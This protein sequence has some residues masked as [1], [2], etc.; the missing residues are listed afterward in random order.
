MKKQQCVCKLGR[1]PD[2]RSSFKK[3]R[4]I[5]RR[6][7]LRQACYDVVVAGGGPSGMGAALAAARQ[8]AR[9]LLVE[10]NGFSGGNAT[11]GYVLKFHGFVSKRRNYVVRGIPL[12]LVRKMKMARGACA[13][14]D[15]ADGFVFDPEC[16][17]RTADDLLAAAGVE[18]LFHSFAADVIRRKHD[19]EGV[20]IENKSGPL[21]VRGKVFIDA[22]GTGDVAIRAGAEYQ[23]GR[24]GDQAMQ[25]MSLGFRLG[26]VAS[27]DIKEIRPLMRQGVAAG[28]IPFIGGP[29]IDFTGASPR[30]GEV[31]VNAVRMWGD[32]SDV[33]DLT[34]AEIEGRK[35]VEKITAF[36]KKKA[37]PFSKCFLVDSAPVISFREANHILGDYIL[38][39]EDVLAGRKFEDGIAA[40][41]WGVDIHSPTPGV[42][43]N[44]TGLDDYYLIPYRC[45]LVKGI[46]NLLVAGGPA[47]FSHEA[48]ASTR[49]M[50]T[51]M[52]MGQAAGTAAALSVR[53]NKSL[54]RIDVDELREVL[55]KKDVY[56]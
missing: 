12:E 45:L 22:T 27:F 25:P 26:N 30:N 47:S 36:L 19:L 53:R 52:A 20:V 7:V 33:F 40:G 44:C 6:T 3:G 38:T 46:G 23:K 55:K 24:K 9:T 32:A 42:D 43:W 2:A 51:C 54:R 14:A 17:K 16:W 41:V 4:F 35:A 21:L 11:A 48:W 49:V 34:R 13:V 8:G 28:E 37:K 50:G 1:C 39:K 29:W 15:C 56:L 5:Y 31:L 10:Q 18:V